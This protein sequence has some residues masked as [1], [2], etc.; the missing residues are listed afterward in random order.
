MPAIR[1]K[2]HNPQRGQRKHLLWSRLMNLNLMIY[3]IL[4]PSRSYFKIVTSEEIVDRLIS[5]AVKDKL[6]KDDFEVIVPPEYNAN[7]TIVLRNLDSL[8][9]EVDSEEL[10]EDVERRN[11]WIKVNEIIKLPN[12]PK[13]LKLKLENSEMVKTA[14]EKGIMIYNLSVPPFNVDK[15]IFVYVNIC[16]NCYQYS[17][18]TEECPTPD[19]TV[20][21]ECSARTHRFRD[22]QNPR[23]QCLNC[24]GAHRTLA[25]VCPIRKEII[26]NKSREIRDRSRS[27]SRQARASAATGTT[28]YAQAARGPR[29]E[30]ENI[31]QGTVTKEENIKIISSIQYAIT[32]EGIVPGSFHLNIK[33]MYKI[34]GLPQVNFPKYIPSPNIQGDKIQEEIRKMRRIFEQVEESEGSDTSSVDE[35]ET[36]METEE[37]KE[38]RKRPAADTPSPKEQREE[39][40]RQ[41]KTAKKETTTEGAT[42]A[43]EQ[44]AEETYAEPQRPGPSRESTEKAESKETPEFRKQIYEKHVKEMKF[45]FVKTMETELKKGDMPEVTALLK[46]GKLKYIYTNPHYKESNC[47]EV[48]EKGYVRLSNTEIKTITRE[49]F[50]KIA[51]NGQLMRERH[52]KTSVGSLSGTLERKK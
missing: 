7:K 31:V 18:K 19:I 22:C 28:T 9:T 50:A 29:G 2:D 44:R 1:I 16:Y 41:R 43:P 32:M 38:S 52:R 15:D 51:Y 37:Q 30:Q 47:R 48:W 12:A 13:I 20:C 27:R 17:H 5:S 8:I 25:A 46:Q 6:R 11:P 39:R 42:A 24:D 3:K 35:D 21:S 36:E 10:K 45:C 14:R 49:E 23:K 33:E 26:K 4:D 34:N 40:E